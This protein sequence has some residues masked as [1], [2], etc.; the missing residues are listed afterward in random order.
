MI[1]HLIT[2]RRRLAPASRQADAV[3]CVVEQA[4]LAVEAGVNVIQV[5][6]RDLDGRDLAD[7]V[8]AVVRVTRG[9]PTRVVVNDRVDVALAADAD[10]VHLRADSMEARHVRPLV[11]PGFVI[12]RSVHSLEEL[13]TS[14][15]VDYV[16]AGTVWPT[17]SKS[18]DWPLL[19]VDMLRAI[20]RAAAVPVVAIGGVAAERFAEAAAAGAAGVA[21]IGLFMSA[22]NEGCRACPL[23]DVARQFRAVF[24]GVT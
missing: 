9:S 3:A 22:S 24:A 23:H 19:G 13:E 14:G 16:L 10:G 6:E 12:G 4:R 17:P 5:R 21:G 8:A 7:L 2:D 1:L 18:T 20:A 11:P 15:P